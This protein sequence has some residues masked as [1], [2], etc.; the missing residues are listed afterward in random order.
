MKKILKARKS[1]ETITE[2]EV[3]KNQNKKLHKDNKGKF[4]KNVLR[5]LTGNIRAKL[6]FSFLVP[7]VLIVILGG[8]AYTISSNAISDRFTSSTISLITSTGS[9][10]DVITQNIRNRAVELSTDNEIYTYYNGGYGEDAVT[11]LLQGVDYLTEDEVYAKIKS[12]ITTLVLMD[13]YIE[14]LTIFTD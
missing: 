3:V 4:S 2:P 9:H 1:M 10:Y 11:E 6:L 13:Q 12:K 14:N 7:I 8:T 5:H